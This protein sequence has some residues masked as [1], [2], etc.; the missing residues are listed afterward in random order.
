M[1]SISNGLNYMLLIVSSGHSYAEKECATTDDGG[2]RGEES[3]ARKAHTGTQIPHGNHITLQ[4]ECTHYMT[5]L[6]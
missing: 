3:S 1:A 5:T 4:R 2:G 6:H